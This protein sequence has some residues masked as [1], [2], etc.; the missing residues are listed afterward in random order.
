MKRDFLVK[1]NKR[2][3][4]KNSRPYILDPKR[5]INIDSYIDFLVAK[6]ILKNE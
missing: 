4:G 2:Y 1:K 6:I 5:S 3:G